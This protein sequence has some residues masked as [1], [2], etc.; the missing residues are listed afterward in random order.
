M[1]ANPRPRQALR[2]NQRARTGEAV[3]H[4]LETLML[5]LLTVSPLIDDRLLII[6]TG[7]CQNL[8][9]FCFAC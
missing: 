4:S 6:S 9:C 8:F 7:C 3:R 5:S 1:T 2:A